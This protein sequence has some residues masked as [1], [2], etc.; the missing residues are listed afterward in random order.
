MKWLYYAVVQIL[1]TAFFWLPLWWWHIPPIGLTIVVMLCVTKAWSD[2]DRPSIKP[3]PNRLMVDE[4]LIFNEIMGDKE[5][6][7]SGRYAYGPSWIGPWNPRGTI[8]RA[9]GWNCRNWMA[10]FNYLTWPWKSAPPLIVKPYGN[11]HQLKLGWQ[12]RYGATVMVC[13]LW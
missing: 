3:L 5:D 8:L 12:Q 13:S 1:Q 2:A 9:I 11:G 6:G 4:F 7:A 10:N